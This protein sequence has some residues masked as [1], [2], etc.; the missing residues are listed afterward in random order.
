ME[1]QKVLSLRNFHRAEPG[2]MIVLDL[3]IE[4]RIPSL[5]Q[6]FHEVNEAYFGSVAPLAEHRLTHKSP[7]EGHAVEPT[8]QFAVTIGLDAV[9][10]TGAVEIDE[11][12]DDIFVYP[13]LRTVGARP[14]NPLEVPIH[15]HIV[16]TLADSAGQRFRDTQPI[17]FQDGARIGTIKS[18]PTVLI[19]HRES[20]GPV[21]RFEDL[22]G[23]PHDLYDKS[24]Y[25]DHAMNGIK[26]TSMSSARATR[27]YAVP[28]DELQEPI[29]RA[30]EKLRRWTLEFS[31]ERGFKALRESAIFHFKD[32]ITIRIQEHEYGSEATFESASRVGKY[33]FG[34][35][36]RNLR[37]L[38][39]AVDQELR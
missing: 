13:G 39:A 26:R 16:N 3:A 35:N 24:S 4:Q 36:P 5:L 27:L 22:W 7:T 32:E 33:D 18:Y 11:S 19:G 30:I 9:G 20:P 28:P 1:A 17:Q 6:P 29:G 8:D 2:E 10:P 31:G 34:Q 38:L 23:Q 21:T 37:R 12:A 25:N 14:D 15:P